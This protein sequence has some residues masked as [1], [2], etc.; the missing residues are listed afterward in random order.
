VSENSID[1]LVKMANQIASGV[2]VASPEDKIESTASHLCRFWT[3]LMRKQI[4]EFV[5]S[6]GQGLNPIATQAVGRLSAG[7]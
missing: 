3:P 1:H 6:G 4:S 7:K 2:P 5:A